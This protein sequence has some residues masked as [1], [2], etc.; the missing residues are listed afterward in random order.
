MTTAKMTFILIAFILVL[1]TVGECLQTS[2]P[3]GQELPEA[4][5]GQISLTISAVQDPAIFGSPVNIKI[6]TTNVSPA[7]VNLAFSIWSV[8]AALTYRVIIHDEQGNVP[9]D[10]RLSRLVK[11]YRQSSVNVPPQVIT[12]SSAQVPLNPGQTFDDTVDIG[13]VYD[14]SEPGKYTVQIQRLDTDDQ[15]EATSNT[16][17]INVTPAPNSAQAAATSS[18]PPFSLTI[19]M[20]PSDS[21]SRGTQVALK[22]STENTSDH[23]I[24]LWA[25]TADNRQGNSTYQISIHAADGSVP[26][27]TPIGRQQ[28]ARTDVPRGAGYSMTSAATKGQRFALRPG[29]SWTD[30][31]M[32]NELYD[33]NK[34]GQYTIQ[35]RRFDPATGTMVT[36]NDITLTIAP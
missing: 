33:L 13:T 11:Y 10:A 24:S 16:I 35:V 17:T 22:I 18:T 21:V 7:S 36:S 12:G 26:A 15:V 14:L 19:K 1:N 25:D 34:P 29:E 2:L 31:V 9:G 27:D 20:L 23:T 6:A 3:S 32:L 4:R 8:R 28:K 5:Q 30:T